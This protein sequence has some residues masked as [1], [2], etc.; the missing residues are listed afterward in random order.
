MFASWGTLVILYINSKFTPPQQQK[1]E[2]WQKR[3]AKHD[4]IKITHIT[5]NHLRLSIRIPMPVPPSTAASRGKASSARASPPPSTPGRIRPPWAMVRGRGSGRSPQ[6][7]TGGCPGPRGAGT[8]L[9]ALCTSC[10]GS[11]W[12]LSLLGL[13]RGL[14]CIF[15]GFVQSS[16]VC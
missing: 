4:S 11:G 1:I 13:L 9:P 6:G 8:C 5:I 7:S 10:D 16:A 15:L 2:C 14:G 3:E 12:C